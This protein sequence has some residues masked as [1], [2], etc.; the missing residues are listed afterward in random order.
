M[1]QDQVA[2]AIENNVTPL[3]NK[4]DD[5]KIVS[6]REALVGRE[7]LDTF[8]F[9]KINAAISQET[10]ST[11][12][13]RFDEISQERK[14][15]RED[16]KAPSQDNQLNDLNIKDLV[17]DT[18]SVEHMNAKHTEETSLILASLNELNQNMKSIEKIQR[19]DLEVNR[20]L[21]RQ[22]NMRY[23]AENERIKYD[24]KPKH[25]QRNE[26]LNLE[27]ETSDGDIENNELEKLNV[28]AKTKRKRVFHDTVFDNTDNEDY[29]DTESA[30]EID[31]AANIIED[32][33]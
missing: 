15:R 20:L 16:I 6:S 21:A 18:L 32:V 10:E 23:Q 11:D 27:V 9:E 22:E 29:L 17:I 12:I 5:E 30:Y 4:A 3:T 8:K 33:S 19:E 24:L 2:V 13:L 14:R 31:E 1:S 28:P 26:N 7:L 25:L